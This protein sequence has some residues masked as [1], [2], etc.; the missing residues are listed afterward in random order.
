MLTLRS[1]KIISEYLHAAQH[2]LGFLSSEMWVLLRFEKQTDRHN[3]LHLMLARS[4]CGI[5]T[6]QLIIGKYLSN[7]FRYCRCPD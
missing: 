2:S 6:C 1:L 3:L 7:K 4:S 5:Q